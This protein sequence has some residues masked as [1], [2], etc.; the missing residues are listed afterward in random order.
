MNAIALDQAP[1]SVPKAQ[2]WIGRV[3][4]GLIALF[5]AVDG[6]ARLAGFAPYV[7]GTVRYGYP[8]SSAPW[9][10]A[11]LLVA[12]ALYIVPRSAVLGAILLTGYLGGA[13]ATHVRASE[14]WFFAA[15]FGVIVWA[16][17]FLRD[18][19]VRELLLGSARTGKGKQRR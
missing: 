19:H 10:G 16:G 4:V 9:I 17:L 1:L 7:E 15:V 11:V 18:A 13:I 12:T 14:P 5:M 6:A 3:L 8:L 2:L